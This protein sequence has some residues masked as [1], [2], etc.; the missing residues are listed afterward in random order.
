M[1]AK[2]LIDKIEEKID[3]DDIKTEIIKTELVERDST[4]NLFI[5]F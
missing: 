5:K 2:R 1:A 3:F 4:K